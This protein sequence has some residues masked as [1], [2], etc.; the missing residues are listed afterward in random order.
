MQ[1]KFGVRAAVCDL[2]AG[3]AQ[4]PGAPSLA[5]AGARNLE[6][7]SSCATR[8][9]R[10]ASVAPLTKG[11]CASLMVRAPRSPRRSREAVREAADGGWLARLEA[12]LMRRVGCSWRRAERAAPRGKHRA[13]RLSEAWEPDEE[14]GVPGLGRYSS[15][16][17]VAVPCADPSSPPT[18]SVEAMAVRSMGVK[19]IKLELA[20]PS[21]LSTE[22]LQ[23]L[24]ESLEPLCDD[25]R[26]A[27]SPLL[28]GWWKLLHASSAPR[29]WGGADRPKFTTRSSRHW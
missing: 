24:A 26:V 27:T 6:L 25:E 20:R 15:D 3:L 13:L 11:D 14:G 22:R 1:H 23:L 29:W 18:M 21:S 2:H 28:D 19:A 12:F 5:T 8:R 4:R 16:D 7:W 10:S 9:C 17:L